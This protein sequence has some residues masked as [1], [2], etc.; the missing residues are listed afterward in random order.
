MWIKEMNA[1]NMLQ[2]AQHDTHR[3]FRDV[4]TAPYDRELTNTRSIY[5]IIVC[6]LPKN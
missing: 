2:Q 3:S 5:Y 6:K 1:H 4:S